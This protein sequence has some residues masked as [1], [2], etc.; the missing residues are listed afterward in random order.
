MTALESEIETEPL[1]DKELLIEVCKALVDEP[2][3]IHIEE[4]NKDTPYSILL[5]FAAPE[6]RGK[7][8]GMKG[9]TIRLIREI[10][11]RIAARENRRI[12]IEVSDPKRMPTF[13]RIMERIMN[14]SS[15]IDTDE[16]D[17][18][19]ERSVED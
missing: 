4:L 11:S 9:E 5:I 19:I 14:P 17:E 10:F 13:P 2:Q 16:N 7:L 1:E 8:I 18:A 12:F 6:D 3:K 15:E